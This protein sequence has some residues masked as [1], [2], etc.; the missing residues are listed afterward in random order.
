MAVILAVAT[1][2]QSR[3]HAGSNEDQD[4]T[5]QKERRGEHDRDSREDGKG[6]G[7]ESGTELGLD[8]TYDKVRSGARLIMA[9][10]AQNKAFMG[11]VENTTERTLKRVRVEVHLSNGIELG[12][13]KA[14]NLAPGKKMSVELTPTTMGFTGASARPE[15]DGWDTAE[16]KA[17]L[18]SGKVS[19]VG[20]AEVGTIDGAPAEQRS[21]QTY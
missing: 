13:T 16:R 20:K 6:E 2:I 18:S 9:Y 12:P 10:D 7:E 8:A 21:A 15:V 19:T 1:S 4:Q 11:T 5:N 3:S 14:T 17:N